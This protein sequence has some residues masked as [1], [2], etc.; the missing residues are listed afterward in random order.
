MLF[1]RSLCRQTPR[2]CLLLGQ[3]GLLLGDLSLHTICR[4][5]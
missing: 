1:Y 5:K 3:C 2:P 4:M